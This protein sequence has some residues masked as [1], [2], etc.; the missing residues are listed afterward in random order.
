M[1]K[2]F[3]HH[4]QK[5]IFFDGVS[6]GAEQKPPAAEGITLILHPVSSPVKILY[7]TLTYLHTKFK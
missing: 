5:V 3:S 1:N 2:T 6:P 7:H 4:M